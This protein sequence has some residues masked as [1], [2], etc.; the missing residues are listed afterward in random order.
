MFEYR[1]FRRREE[2]EHG[3]EKAFYLFGDDNANSWAHPILFLKKHERGYRISG[4]S[5]LTN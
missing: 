1:A 2:D 5:A 3:D 4:F